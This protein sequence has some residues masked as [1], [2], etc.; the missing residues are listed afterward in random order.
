M[1]EA[2]DTPAWRHL[3]RLAALAGV[4]DIALRHPGALAAPA[5]VPQYVDLTWAGGEVESV[6]LPASDDPDELAH[7]LARELRIAL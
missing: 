3:L 4:V 6:R 5:G 1:I 7:V 2:P